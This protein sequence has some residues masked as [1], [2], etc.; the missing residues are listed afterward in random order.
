MLTNKQLNL[1]RQVA[2]DLDTD[3]GFREFA[4]PDPLSKLQKK[5]PN[6]P[7][8]FKP[9]REIAPPGINWDEGNPWTYGHGFT[10]GVTPDSRISRIQSDRKLEN[11]IHEMDVAL[12]TVLPTWY[13]DAS[14]ATKT[15]LLNM[16]HQLGLKGLLGF[17]NTLAYMKAHLFDRAA[18]GM[19]S[20]L[21]AKQ[22][23]NRAKKYAARLRAQKID[24]AQL[25]PELK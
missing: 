16:C 18:D 21:W 20:S 14:T 19:L 8:G 22:T 17:K 23:P 10:K 1:Y 6:L 5:Y 9:A 2:H 3:E 11:A 12:H 25:A 15:V 4:Y 7:W 13:S 24:P